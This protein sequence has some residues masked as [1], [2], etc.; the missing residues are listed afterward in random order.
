MNCEQ[1]E[2][3]LSA[4]LDNALAL[5]ERHGVATHLK[6][7]SRCSGILA[8]FRRFDVLIAHL[9]RVSPDLAL[10]NRIFSAP[11]YLELTGTVNDVRRVDDSTVPHPRTQRDTLQRPKL[12]ALP[13]GRS[14]SASSTSSRQLAPIHHLY[15][16]KQGARGLRFMQA[17]IAAALLLTVGVTSY[18]GWKLWHT[19]VGLMTKTIGITPP[20]GPSQGPIPA[21]TRFVFLRDGTLWSG[22]TDGSTQVVRL[23]PQ[24][25]TVATNWTVQPALPGHIAGDLLAYI[26][27]QK[28]FVHLIR[29]DGQSDRVIPQ[30]L[31]KVGT[32]PTLVWDTETGT[33][34]LNSLVWSKDGSMLAFVAD[35][36]GI[37]QTSLYIYSSL[38][39]E[40]HQVSLPL[41]GSASHPIW[42][43]DSVRIAFKFTHNGDMG[44]LDYNIQN[45]GVLTIISAVNTK[46]NPTDNIITLDWSSDVNVPAITWSVGKEGQIHSIWQR[47]VGINGMAEVQKLAQGMYTQALYRQSRHS[48]WEGW[49]L[50]SSLSNHPGDIERVDLT[51]RVTRLTNG[52]QVAFVQWSPDGIRIIYL[53]AVS[54]GR[55]TL[56]QIDDATGSDTVL[57]TGVAQDPPPTWSPDSRYIAYSTGMHTFFLDV[58]KDKAVQMSKL[59]G[60]PSAFA[61]CASQHHQ[62]IVALA[63]NQPG[64]YLVDTQRATVLKLDK[65]AA[66]GPLL[67]TQ[68]P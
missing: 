3:L 21:G 9:P 67:W 31:L 28:G 34:I 22:P 19:Q 64:I 55:G 12:V 42:S 53:D 47:H 68:I 49:L 66:Q 11:Q 54:S 26:D 60:S 44:I 25:V 16:Q 39:E 18:I 20:A 32:Q 1:V 13:G 43:P 58:L 8:D 15:P 48:G 14:S 40:V 30:P 41:K 4:Y 10:R 24:N 38:T 52:K 59:L 45:H 27:L 36:Q 37:G 51:G 5:E 57:A 7:C 65:E 33:A 46:V 61:W 50:V 23:T 17:M 62:F 6:A 29:S 2:E 63:D 56:H 35:P